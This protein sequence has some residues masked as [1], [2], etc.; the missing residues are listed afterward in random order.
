MILRENPGIRDLLDFIANMMFLPC[1][2]KRQ[3]PNLSTVTINLFPAYPGMMRRATANGL[4]GACLRRQSGSTQ[5]GDQKIIFT[6]GGMKN[7]M[8]DYAILAGMSIT[9]HQLPNILREQVPMG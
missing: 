6:P 1:G 5:P 8:R 3:C 4:E 9:P 7:H 2:V